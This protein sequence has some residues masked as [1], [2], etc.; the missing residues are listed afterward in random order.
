MNGASEEWISSFL[1][2]EVWDRANAFATREEAIEDG[3]EQYRDALDGKGS[4]LFEDVDEEDLE[5][6]K[7]FYVARV[8]KF[9]P[10]VD[11]T[12]VLDYVQEEA[13]HR[14][15]ECAEDYLER[16]PKRQVDDLQKSL[17]AAFDDW[18]VRTGNEP[19]FFKCVD[20]EEVSIEQK[21]V[22]E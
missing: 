9:V 18:L 20:V 6:V 3:R 21:A 4:E 17:Q 15:G 13:W 5:R 1:P 11:F 22:K 10:T 19:T 8:K 2:D 12:M 7:S 16:I 14:Y